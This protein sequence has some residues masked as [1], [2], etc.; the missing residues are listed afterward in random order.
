LGQEHVAL[1]YSFG[2]TA[3]ALLLGHTTTYLK[4][5]KMEKKIFGSETQQEIK[6]T[7]SIFKKQLKNFLRLFFGLGSLTLIMISTL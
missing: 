7:G 4:I 1:G 5:R 3:V 6:R 2:P